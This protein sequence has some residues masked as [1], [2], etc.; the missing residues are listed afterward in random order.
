VDDDSRSVQNP[1][2]RAR[3]RRPSTLQPALSG[4][5]PPATIPAR[6]H[7]TGDRGLTE[8]PLP[9]ARFSRVC[10][11]VLVRPPRPL[12]GSGRPTSVRSQSQG[13]PRPKEGESRHGQASVAWGVGR[14]P[15]WDSSSWRGLTGC[16]ERRYTIPDESSRRSG[17][18]EQRGD[19]KRRPFPRRFYYYGRSWTSR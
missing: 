17:R 11:H 8:R 18:G 2:V 14:P 7:F 10:P 9:R 13:V 12:G 3:T 19:R 16:V 1:I 15:C 6:L 5:A 4:V